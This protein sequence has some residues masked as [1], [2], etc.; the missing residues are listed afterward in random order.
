M[1]PSISPPNQSLGES[2]RGREGREGGREPEDVYLLNASEARAA[3]LFTHK[4]VVVAHR[5][6]VTGQKMADR[7]L[8]AGETLTRL[9]WFQMWD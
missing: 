1:Q 9:I 7:W 4:P 2:G 6:G 5:P 3:S 8:R